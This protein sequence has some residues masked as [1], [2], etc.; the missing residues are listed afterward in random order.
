MSATL[1][2]MV[3][4]AFQEW[5]KTLLGNPPAAVQAMFPSAPISPACLQERN[6]IIGLPLIVTRPRHMLTAL[7]LPAL[8][9]ISPLRAVR[10]VLA[11]PA[12]QK[13]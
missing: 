13:T 2:L 5:Q 8:E 11:R 9:N 3:K 7:M 12:V 1:L 6:I 4:M 10:P